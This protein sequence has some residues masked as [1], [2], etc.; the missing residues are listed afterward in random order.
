MLVWTMLA[1]FP[2][3]AEV[4][5]L[6]CSFLRGQRNS[7]TMERRENRDALIDTNA[8]R[9]NSRPCE[10]SE[11]SFEWK[12]RPQD[13]VQATFSLNRNTGQLE[14]EGKTYNVFLCL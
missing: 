3:V 9:C 6:D 2:C 13:P 7:E 4:I 5:A 1:A 10:I 12:S 8:G 11:Q 14:V